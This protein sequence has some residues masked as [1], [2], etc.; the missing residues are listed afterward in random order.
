MLD[1]AASYSGAMSWMSASLLASLDLDDIAKQRRENF[2]TLEAAIAPL[3]LE[4][5]VPLD[6]RRVPLFLPVRVQ[7][8]DRVRRGLAARGMFCPAHWPRPHGH[9]DALAPARRL[10]DSELSL[11]IDQRYD[12]SDMERIAEALRDLDASS[13]RT[14]A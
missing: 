1:L 13:D 3:G 14:E 7:D 6:G 9:D 2:R 5:I 12:G 8:R 11:I 10:Y 4:S